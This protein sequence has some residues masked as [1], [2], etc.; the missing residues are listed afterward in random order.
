MALK[1]WIAMGLIC[2]MGLNS[3]AQRPGALGEKTIELD[4]FDFATPIT[5]IFP[6]RYISSEWGTGWYQIPSPLAPPSGYLYEKATCRDYEEKPLWITYTHKSG[7]TADELLH[8]AGQSFYTADFA[9]TL[10]GRIVAVGGCA[11]EM[12]QEDCDR[13]IARLTELYGAPERSTGNFDN[14]LYKWESEERIWTFAI[15]HTDE[16][17]VLN[18]EQIWDEED[19]T[20]EIREGERRNRLECYFF[21]FDSAWYDLYVSAECIKQGDMT[22][23]Y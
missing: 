7:N 11:Y 21:V 22:T 1:T 2:M 9:T 13:F 19:Q 10:E 3:C 8:M 4:H 6:D 16:H 5:D 12:T 23:C 20:L 14:D 18:L 15:N 17:N